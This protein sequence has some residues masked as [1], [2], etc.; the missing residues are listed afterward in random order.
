MKNNDNSVR[1]LVWDL[2]K[3]RDTKFIF[4]NPGS[5]ELPF[6][7]NWPEDITWMMSLHEGTAAAMAD[8]YAQATGK[9][10]F[11]VLHSAAGLANALSSIY[12]GVR[13]YTPLVV[14]AGQQVRSLH[15]YNAYLYAEEA[16]LLPK[17]YIKWGIESSLAA[18]V[19]LDLANAFRLSSQR[20][21]GPTFISVPM[22]D[23][24]QPG[25]KPQKRNFSDRFTGDI[26][27]L[28]KVSEKL[29]SAK[30]VFIVVGPELDRDGATELAVDLAERIGAKV[31]LSPHIDRHSF[32]EDHPSFRG[33]LQPLKKNIKESLK[34]ADLVL[35][36]GAPV[37]LY[38]LPGEGLPLNEGIDL[39]QLTENP[40]IISRAEMGIG[41][42]TSLK[43]GLTIILKEI[44]TDLNISIPEPLPS[45]HEKEHN[46]MSSSNVLQVLG[47]NLPDDTII[48][49]EAPT[50]REL[51]WQY[52]PIR[53]GGSYYNGGSGCLGWGVPASMG[54]SLANSDK[55]VVCIVGD[56]SIQYAIQAFWTASQHNIKVI[57]VVLNN[58]EYAAMKELSLTFQADN[59]PSYDLPNINITDIIKGYGCNAEKVS[60][61][62]S[63]KKAIDK[64]L[65]SRKTTVID[66]SIDTTVSPLY[67]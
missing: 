13:N 33:Q 7:A 49:E 41:I 60:N 8:G 65:D 63:L 22:D 23:W 45:K 42:R 66:V 28:Q 50:I 9:P 57:V 52:F 59:P 56:G 11:L 10:A 35:V 31:W 58:Q 48:V 61:A 54:I 25:T 27:E 30:N 47:E 18:N 2:L 17:P 44:P 64:A 55:T 34:N 6:F 46:P 16:T 5:T 15:P 37:F 53:K 36:L 21:Y 32:P 62:T 26:E 29:K 12:T 40:E 51:R 1:N 39:I 20:P 38:H 19:P 43:N 3:E 14:M 67:S 4:G 24:N